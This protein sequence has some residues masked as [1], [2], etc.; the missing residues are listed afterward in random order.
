M[1]FA[2]LCLPAHAAEP[3][4]TDISVIPVR[5]GIN[6]IKRFAADSRTAIIV[7]AW[8]DNGNAHGYDVYLV[9]LPTRADNGTNHW[10][11]EVAF[12]NGKDALEDIVSASPFDGERVLG[13][14]LFARAKLDGVP[15]TVMVRA[16]LGETTSGALADHAPVEISVYRL[17]NPGIDVGTTP[18]VFH[19]IS[20]IHPNGRFCNADMAL[21]TVLH[22]PL[23]AT[24]AGGKAP[25]GCGD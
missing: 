13:T 12:D 14:V 11:G 6:T 1:L 10:T 25:S 18:D 5:D 3:A 7:R 19:L 17:E 16:D 15:A 20:K 8:R 4:L 21:A 24:Y 9:L 2:T 22:I 23:P